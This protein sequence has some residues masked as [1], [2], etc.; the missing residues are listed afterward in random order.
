MV[1]GILGLAAMILCWAAGS[2]WKKVYYGFYLCRCR[3]FGF[4]IA[5]RWMKMAMAGVLAG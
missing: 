2:Y 5:F 4:C 1:L 3:F